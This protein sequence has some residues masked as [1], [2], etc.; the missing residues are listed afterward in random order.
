MSTLGVEIEGDYNIIMKTF[1]V[2]EDP[3][4]VNTNGS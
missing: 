1:M 4:S 3:E 2:K